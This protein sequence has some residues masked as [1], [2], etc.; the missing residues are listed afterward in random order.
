LTPRISVNSRRAPLSPIK[1]RLI[2]GAALRIESPDDPQSLL[3]Q[4]TVLCQTC[5]PFRDPGDDVRTWERLNGTVHLKVN[6]GEAMHPEQGRLVPLGLPF[7]PKARMILM[8]INQQALRQDRPVIEIQHTLTQFVQRALNLDTHGRNMRVVKEQLARLSA[9][10]I[11][12][13]VIRDGR[14]ITVNS[15]IVSAFDL[16]FPKDDRQRVLWPSTIQLSLDYWESL[17]THAVPLD[18]EHI[19]RLSHSALALDI[20]AW[21]ANRLHR[22]P[23]N[24]GFH[25][26]SWREGP[27]WQPSSRSAYA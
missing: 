23:A 17:K 9:S 5:L 11:R 18:E 8:H 15:Q 20:Y 27:S 24:R 2:D 3:F 14:A 13:G 1:K 16:W 7:G 21:L 12:L 19:A 10:S 22:I 6:A 4:H 26:Q 25:A